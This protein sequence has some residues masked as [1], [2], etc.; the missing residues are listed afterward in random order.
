MLF[1][2][3]TFFVCSVSG[4]NLA[5]SSKATALEFT[6]QDLRQ[7]NPE[8][9]AIKISTGDSEHIVVLFLSAKCPCS[10]SHMQEIKSLA[11]DFPDF[12]FVAINSNKNEPSEV[13][14]G[15][16]SNLELSF[17]VLRDENLKYADLLKAVKTPHAFVLDKNGEILYQGGVSDSA[18]FPNAKRLFLREALT[19]LKSKKSIKTPIARALG[20]AIARSE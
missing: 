2:L 11:A 16:F 3:L 19:D 10:I 13:G 1:A 7:S 14:S 20:C 4:L 6:G 5:N 8:S 15:F 9:T 18:K 17:P 12:K